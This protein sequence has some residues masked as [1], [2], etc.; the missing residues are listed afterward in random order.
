MTDLLCGATT[1][2]LYADTSDTAL[3]SA[4]VVLT[5]PASNGEYT[6]TIDT[7]VDL[8]LIDNE[9]SVTHNIQVKSTLSEYTSR[10][11]Y[12][13]L[14]ITITEIGCDCSAL[15]WDNPSHLTPTV[16]VGTPST[17]TVPIPTA[18]TAATATNNAFQKCYLNSGTCATTGSFLDSTGIKY[19]DGTTAGGV[20]LP[21]W[22]TYTSTSSTTQTVTLDPPDGTY[23]GTHTVL[24]TF[25]STHGSDPTYTAFVITVTC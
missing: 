11:N 4:W 19:D 9:A 18:N 6:I 3:S 25:S 10:T 13:Q 5:G 1:F 22:I 7:T 21:S 17:Q 15:A 24:A 16:A 14:T 12:S 23:V 8:T 2:A 20:T